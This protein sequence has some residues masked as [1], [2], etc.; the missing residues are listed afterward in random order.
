[1]DRFEQLPESEKI[2]R[3]ARLAQKALSAYGLSDVELICLQASTHSTFEVATNDPSRHYALRICAADWSST[4]LQREILWLT[5]LCRD[6]EIMVPE[7][8]LSTDGQLI[9]KVAIAGVP[10]F[11]LCTL[12]RWVEGEQRNAELTPENLESIGRLLATLHAHATTFRWPDEIA[13]HRRDAAHIAE[14]LQDASLRSRFSD[15]S[16]NVFQRAIE[17][18]GTTM[19]ELGSGSNV[20]GAIHS[21][22]TP[23]NLR[24]I[25]GEA[26][27]IGFGRCRWDYFLYDLATLGSYIA[28]RDSG[29]RLVAALFAGY[30]SIRDLPESIEHR[31]PAFLALRSIDRIRL[32]LSNPAHTA[33]TV[34]DIDREYA[35]LCTLVEAS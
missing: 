8:M 35:A 13:S 10:G 1:M 2:E 33:R 26:G 25:D 19:V 4:A 18:I 34:R 5:S 3:Y 22:V 30:R 23:L 11:R 31:I 9:R 29:D 32:L 6:T 16:F 12:L 21:Q 20:A 17:W 27:A 24:F 15:A 14:I 7:P 28:A